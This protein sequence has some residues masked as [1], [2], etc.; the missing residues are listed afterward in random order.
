MD[1]L[2]EFLQTSYTAYHA[3][4][5]AKKLLLENGFSALSERKDWALRAGGKYFVERDSALIAFTL[6]N[7]P[8][9]YSFSIVASHLDSPALKVKQNPLI[10]TEGYY[11]LNVEKYGGGILYS[12]LDRPLKLAGR[13]IIEAESG[14]LLS[15]TYVS[16]Y[17]L[18]IPSVA[19]HMNRNVNDGLSLNAQVDMCPLFSLASC[20][21][22]DFLASLTNEKVVDYDLYLVNTSS[23]FSF[24]ANNEFIAS[25]RVDNLTSAYASLSALIQSNNTNGIKMIALFD[26]EEI[27]NQTTE[28]AASD[29]LERTMKSIATAMGIS[30][31]K[32]NQALAKSFFLSLDVAHA[33]HPNHPE[34]HDPTNRTML[35]GGIV[36][37][38]NSNKAYVTDSKSAALLKTLFNKAGVRYQTFFNRSDALGGSTLGRS[39]LVRVGMLGAD[40]GLAQLAMHSATESFAKSDY[41]EL[42][43]GLLAFFQT[44]VNIEDKEIQIL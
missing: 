21:E 2:I 10:K 43:N 33:V 44:N 34:K 13:V 5:N 38:Y 25:P 26:S 17:S 1:R 9:A 31:S 27:G 7:N 22:P 30:E 6:G 3:V 15:K 28:G 37:K 19:I 29:F 32:F 42:E 41:V 20:C 24:G 36:I 39:F 23:S 11:K 14:K 16:D 35:G 12:M 18:S 40:I 4:E 8:D